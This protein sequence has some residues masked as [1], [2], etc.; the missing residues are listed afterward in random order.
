MPF[1]SWGGKRGKDVSRSSVQVE[2]KRMDDP[3]TYVD[4][5]GVR[6]AVQF[7]KTGSKIPLNNRGGKRARKEPADQ[8]VLITGYSTPND[9]APTVFD[10]VKGQ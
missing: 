2:S 1:N 3:N 10:A 6:G 8:H 4:V 9:D 5:Y 7:K